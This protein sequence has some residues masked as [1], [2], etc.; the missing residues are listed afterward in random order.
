MSR[1]STRSTTNSWP[2]RRSKSKTP[3]WPKHSMPSTAELVG[4]ALRR[5]VR[6]LQSRSQ[7]PATASGVQ[8]GAHLVHA[9]A[10]DAGWRQ[11]GASGRRWRP[12]ARSTGRGRRRPAGEQ[13]AEE[14]LAARARPGPG[15]RA[16][17]AGRAAASS[18]QLWS[19]VL[20]KPSPG[21]RTIRS[22]AMPAASAPR[23]R[24]ASSARTV[25]TT[26]P[27]RR[28]SRA[29]C[30]TSLWARQCMATYAAPRSATTSQ[31]PRV[32]QAAGDVVDDRGARRRAPP[33]PPRRAWCRPRRRRRPRRARG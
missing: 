19:A 18:S 21:S 6:G 23:R 13:G 16:P 15:A 26:P 4:H 31:D 22:R 20:A 27:G 17:R 25:A 24:S 12:R 11:R 29:R 32:G 2:S 14:R 8:A 5:R 10:P 33:R 28:T 1:P 30:M 9:D 3:W 7:R